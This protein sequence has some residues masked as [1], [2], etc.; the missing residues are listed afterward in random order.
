MIR[1]ISLMTLIFFFSIVLNIIFIYLYFINNNNSIEEKYDN[2]FKNTLILNNI[3]K[4]DQKDVS[5]IFK[6]SPKKYKRYSSHYCF[7][8]MNKK[9][10]LHGP[11]FIDS[12]YRACIIRN[13]CYF[14]NNFIFYQNLK[15]KTY[16]DHEFHKEPT[17]LLLN[18]NPLLSLGNPIKFFV[19][20]V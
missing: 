4:I 13:L 3:K 2:N 16:L 20:K 7:G 6:Y 1:R 19:P 5:N 10:Y 14:N 9:E 18:E 8:S 11:P 12:S 17:G 15:N